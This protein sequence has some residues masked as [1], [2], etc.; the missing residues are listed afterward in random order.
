MCVELTEMSEKLVRVRALPSLQ[1]KQWADV[2]A[3]IGD[4]APRLQKFLKYL[5]TSAE[6]VNKMYKQ[7]QPA[8][9]P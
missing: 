3:A 1:M 6:R 7:M 2:S 9:T 5:E 4:L 8:R